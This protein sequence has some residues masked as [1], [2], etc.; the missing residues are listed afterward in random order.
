MSRFIGGNYLTYGHIF[1]D[2]VLVYVV[3]MYVGVEAVMSHS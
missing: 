3:H 2:A 1:P